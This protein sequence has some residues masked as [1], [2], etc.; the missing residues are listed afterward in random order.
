MIKFKSLTILCVD[1]N[2]EELELS[3]TACWNV[4]WYNFGKFLKDLN[5]YPYMI[6]LLHSK[7]FTKEKCK[8]MSIQDLYTN[9][10]SSI[11][12]HSQK[13]KQLKCHQ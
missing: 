8:H 3:Y 7:V 13:W 12:C 11:A 2:M 1:E 10:H 9:V 5:T 6:R 4:K